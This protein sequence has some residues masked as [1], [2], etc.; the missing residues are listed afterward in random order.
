VAVVVQGLRVELER[1]AGV[2]VAEP[3]AHVDD[4][5]AGV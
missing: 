2:D 4:W 5:D 1:D 3:V